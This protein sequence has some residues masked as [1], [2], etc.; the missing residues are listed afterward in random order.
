MLTPSFIHTQDIIYNIYI[1]VDLKKLVDGD[2]I[3]SGVG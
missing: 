3:S 1:F 2:I